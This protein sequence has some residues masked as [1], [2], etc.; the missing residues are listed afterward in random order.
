MSSAVCMRGWTGL[1]LGP[2]QGPIV[3]MRRRKS[4]RISGSHCRGALAG[5]QRCLLRHHACGATGRHKLRRMD[6]RDER[7]APG[8]WPRQG[9]RIPLRLAALT[10]SPAVSSKGGTDSGATSNSRATA[11][12]TP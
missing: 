4:G 6:R 3:G 9:H 10:A 12:A 1:Q 5:G 7:G 11:I 8:R 2:S